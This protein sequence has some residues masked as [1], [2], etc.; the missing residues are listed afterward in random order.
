MRVQQQNDVR[1]DALRV[2]LRSREN[3]R[4]VGARDRL[5]E[6]EVAG[7][8]GDG[9]GE[10][11][12]AEADQLLNER[13]AGTELVPGARLDVVRGTGEHCGQRHS[14]S[15]DDQPDDQYEKPFA[16]TAHETD[17]NVRCPS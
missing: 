4:G 1:T 2:V 9:A 17:S 5:A 8:H 16:E 13:A 6:T 15:D 3:R 12:G 11:V 10:L 14:L 7:Q